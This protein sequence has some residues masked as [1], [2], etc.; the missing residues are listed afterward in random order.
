VREC[1]S[2]CFDEERTTIGR[3]PPQ[4]GIPVIPSV[5]S[6]GIQEDLRARSFERQLVLLAAAGEPGSSTAA[7]KR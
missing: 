5:P 1:R 4:A 3:P 2:E 6:D 7:E